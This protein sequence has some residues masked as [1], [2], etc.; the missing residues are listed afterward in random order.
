MFCI[1][2]EFFAMYFSQHSSDPSHSTLLHCSHGDL[3][4]NENEIENCQTDC[5]LHICAIRVYHRYLF[6]QFF[7]FAFFCWIFFYPVC[8]QAQYYHLS[9]S[10]QLLSFPFPDGPRAHP[11]LAVRSGQDVQPYKS[12]RNE[13]AHIPPVCY[14]LKMFFNKMFF[15]WNFQFSFMFI[16]RGLMHCARQSSFVF[17]QTSFFTISPEM[18]ELCMTFMNENLHRHICGWFTSC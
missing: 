6:N 4:K 16:P 7:I 9:F 18:N 8:K 10:P 3:V 14:K 11:S 1:E 2:L 15:L 12:H 13:M 5:L 17:N